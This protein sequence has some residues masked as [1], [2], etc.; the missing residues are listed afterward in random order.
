MDDAPANT[1][2]R[3]RPSTNRTVRAAIGRAVADRGGVGITADEAI[4]AAFELASLH[5]PEYL[6]ALKARAQK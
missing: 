5:W 1:T 4:A 3:T 2:F 6:E